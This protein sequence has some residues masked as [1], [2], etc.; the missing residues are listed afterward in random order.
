M[1]GLL[2]YLVPNI[3]TSTLL[4]FYFYRKP[5]GGTIFTVVFDQQVCNPA[6][7]TLMEMLCYRERSMRQ[8]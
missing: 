1:A 2:G 3:G 5:V 6:A 4:L 7:V 8:A